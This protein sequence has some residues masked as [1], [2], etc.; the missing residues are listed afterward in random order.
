MA[1]AGGLSLTG[2]LL[3]FVLIDATTNLWVG[4]H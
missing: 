2:A 3:C 1:T 4:T